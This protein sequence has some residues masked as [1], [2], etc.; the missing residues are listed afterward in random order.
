MN[1]DAV[2]RVRYFDRQF[3]RT[4]DFIDEQAYHLAMRR[5][6]NV[7]HHSWGIVRGL[8]ISF[9]E[10]SFAVAPGMAVDG[11]GRELIVGG[12]RQISV[13][14]F[15]EHGVDDLDVWLAY[16]LVETDAAPPGY[17][18]CG[19][20]AASFTYRVQEQPRIRLTPSPPDPGA[21]NRRIPPDVPDGDVVFD[22]TRTPPDDPEQDFPVFLG[23]IFRQ[24]ARPTQPFVHDVD[25]ANRPYAGLVGESIHSPSGLTRVQV[26]AEEAGDRRRFAVFVPDPPSNDSGQV[27]F[28][29]ILDDGA[30]NVR[31]QTT[32]LG[33]LTMA[34]GAIELGDG[35]HLDGARPWQIYHVSDDQVHHELRIEMGR[36]GTTPGLNQVVIGSWS[37]DDKR[38][39]P[40]L[41][42]SDD[43]TV[44]VHGNL[45]VE[46]RL[47]ELVPRGVDQFSPEANAMLLAAHLSGVAGG[48]VALQP[49]PQTALFGRPVLAQ[50]VGSVDPLTRAMTDTIDAMANDDAV[51]QRFAQMVKSR[52][53]DDGTLAQRIADALTGNGG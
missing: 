22:P 4:Q 49:G 31:G 21:E 17:A 43:G 51:I 47:H 40:C 7:S 53:G 50:L 13:G 11:F 30:V 32:L 29:E 5:R 23:R 8:Q 1:N 15:D 45:V 52:D 46:G 39:H 9:A 16:D 38:F 24:R 27:P 3:L 37:P 25:L 34:H 44:T 2:V 35:G 20:D 48:N 26:G 12:S 18:G 6:H 14:L 33:D 42:V 41:T 19:Q 10:G 28:F 36:Q